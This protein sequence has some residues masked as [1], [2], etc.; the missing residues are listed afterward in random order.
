MDKKQNDIKEGFCPVCVASVPLA[1]SLTTAGATQML[2]ENEDG[3]DDDEENKEKR[4]K[5]KNR[6]KWI[7]IFCLI[8]S[9]LCLSFLIYLK[10][11]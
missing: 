11:S 4:V 3:N 7:L 10:F 1:F 6:T 2:R 8:M 5:S 9:L